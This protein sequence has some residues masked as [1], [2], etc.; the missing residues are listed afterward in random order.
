MTYNQKTTKQTSYY[1]I[2]YD[3]NEP[4]K[5]YTSLEEALKKLGAHKI[6]ETSWQVATEF[7]LVEL[8]NYL[9]SSKGI[10]RNDDFVITEIKEPSK[11]T[12]MYNAPNFTRKHN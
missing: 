7:T 12:Q 8:C 5:D 3:L 9:V 1:S 6:L 10:D 4:N 2:N 11:K